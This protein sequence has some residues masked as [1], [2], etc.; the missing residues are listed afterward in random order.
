[1][2]SVPPNGPDPTT[3]TISIS[4]VTSPT[5]TPTNP[6]IVDGFSST[7]RCLAETNSLVYFTSDDCTSAERLSVQGDFHLLSV[8]PNTYWYTLLGPQN[9][10]ND[11]SRYSK[12]LIG[13]RYL[14]CQ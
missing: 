13:V 5:P 12:V 1:M 2:T 3:T 4:P 11:Y 7:L 9:T 10:C 14:Q 6:V 8:S